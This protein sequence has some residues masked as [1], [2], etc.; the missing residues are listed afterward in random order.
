LKKKKILIEPNEHIDQLIRE[1]MQSFEAAPPPHVWEGVVAGLEANKA[2]KSGITKKVIILAALALFLAFLGWLLLSPYGGIWAEGQSHDSNTPAENVSVNQSVALAMVEQEIK[3]EEAELMEPSS[4]I[5]SGTAVVSHTSEKSY[6][7]DI[8][9][10]DEVVT[11]PEDAIELSLS[12]YKAED[13][14]ETEVNESINYTSLYQS[15]LD[16][17]P[18]YKLNLSL[19]EPSLRY[20]SENILSPVL[21]QKKPRTN[22]SS[23]RKGNWSV[24]VGTAPEFA[25]TNIDSVTVLNSFSVH[26]EPTYHFNKHWFVRSGLGMAYSRDRGFAKLDY[27]SN[28]YMGS[29]NDVYNVTFD[30]VNG[31]VVPTYYTKTVEVWD[32]IRHL[33]VSEV[34]NRYAYVQVPLFVGYYHPANSALVSWYVYGG[35]TFNFQIGRWIDKPLP[36]ENYIEILNLQNKLPERNPFYMQLGI[37][38]GIEYKITDKI[39]MAVEPG[40]RY[41]LNSI[42]NKE[43]YNKSISAFSVKVGAVIRLK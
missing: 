9:S 5:S 20:P 28:E 40:Y 37:S 25:I 42:Y 24:F 23:V 4:G 12:G 11:E 41:Y 36:A 10:T 31:Q 6:A 34:T 35:P 15:F 38:A 26:F 29:Y 19:A 39:S 8:V 7:V 2:A 13:V 32:S 22:K 21:P 3:T 27:I 16:Y 33:V 17:H 14:I 43:G 18:L 1:K 30:S